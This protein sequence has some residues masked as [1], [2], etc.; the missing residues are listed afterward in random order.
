MQVVP[1]M[2]ALVDAAGAL[3]LIDSGHGDPELLG[4]GGGAFGGGLDVPAGRRGGA[5]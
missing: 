5:G 2:G 1:A 3:P 4:Q